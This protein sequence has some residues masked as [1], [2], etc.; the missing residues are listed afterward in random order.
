MINYHS[1]YLVGKLTDIYSGGQSNTI[2]TFLQEYLNYSATADC[3]SWTVSVQ[4]T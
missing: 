1:L 4:R 3:K 2:T